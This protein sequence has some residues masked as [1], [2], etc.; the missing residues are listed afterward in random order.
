MGNDFERFIEEY[1]GIVYR[2]AYSYCGNRA[3][4]EDV[5]QQTFLKCFEKQPV[6]RDKEHEK[7]WLL[8]VAIDLSKDCRKSYWNRNTESLTNEI[9]QMPFSENI[10]D[11]V[12]IW[13]AVAKLS[14]NYRMV[15]W[16]Y[17]MEGYPV[18]EIA[19]ILKRK[20]AT[21]RTWLARARKKLKEMLN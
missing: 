11:T 16:L 8:R 7:A 20:S 4:A 13:D 21:I 3:D 15:I 18:S 5:M 12:E 2:C 1:S 14:P 6:F 10:Q 17:Y 19:V 9:P